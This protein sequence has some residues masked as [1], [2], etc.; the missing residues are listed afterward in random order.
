MKTP[1]PA[2]TAPLPDGLARVGRYV[3]IDRIGAGGMGIVY[4]AYDP[5]L[6]RRVAVKLLLPGRGSGQ[7][8]LA[9]EA[10]AMARVSHPNVVPVHDVG[11]IDER[12][13]IAMEFIDG[14]SLADWLRVQPRGKQ[15]IVTIFRG[16]AAGLAAAHEVGVVHRDF[17]PDNVLVD[18]KGR[19]QVTDFGLAA[20][21]LARTGDTDGSLDTDESQDPPEITRLTRTGAA[22]GTPAYMAPEQFEGGT[23]DAQSD[24]FSFCVALWEA[25]W[26][27]RPF[28]GTSAGDLAWA[29]TNGAI[30]APTA[31]TPAWLYQILVRGL[32]TDP[33]KRWPSM[34]SLLTELELGHARTRWRRIGY[35]FLG[36]F[37]VA[38][39]LEGCRRWEV[40]GRVEAC[41][42]AG[43]QIDA[44]WG[45]DRQQRMRDSFAGTGTAFAAM[46]A[47]KVVPRI[48]RQVMAWKAARAT[49]CLN[50]TVNK[51]WGA[52]TLYLADWCLEDRRT[53]L[54][55]LLTEFEHADVAVVRRALMAITS[56]SESPSC[57]NERALARQSA[58]PISGREIART[59][60]G[61]VLRATSLHLAGR[62]TIGHEVARQA[63]IRAETNLAWPPLLSAAR[64]VEGV[65]LSASGEFHD[66]EKALSEAFFE[67]A[68]AGA[69][70]VAADAAVASIVITGIK[71]SKHDLGYMWN[72]HSELAIGY[73]GDEEELREALRLNNHANMLYSTG[74]YAAAK[75]LHEKALAIRQRKLG[76]D[77]PEVARSLANLAAV[78]EDLGD[79]AGARALDEQALSIR[80]RILGPEHPEVAESLT[81]LGSVL[82]AIGDYADAQ[83]LH[84]RALAIA[85]RALG[86][87]HIDLAMILNNLAVVYD[88]L[89]ASDKA[90]AMYQRALSL[91][92]NSVGREHPSVAKTLRN[93]A[94][95]Y[96][97]NGNLSAALT[98]HERALAILERALGPE[99]PEVATSLMSIANVY[100]VMGRYTDAKSRHQRALAIREK[101]LGADNI[102][103]VASVVNLAGVHMSMGE[104]AEARR[105]Y[106]R[107]LKL[108]DG[109][110]TSDPIDVANV[111]NNLAYLALIDRRHGDAEA[112]YKRALGI[113][114]QSL[115]LEH[116]AVAA[117]LDGLAGVYLAVG[118][119]ADA[120]VLLERAVLIYEMH[121]G[122]QSNEIAAHFDLAQALV[123]TGRE[124]ERALQEAEFALN[125]YAAENRKQDKGYEEIANWL[126][127]N[128]GLLRGKE[129]TRNRA[130]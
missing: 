57:L 130:D 89:G 49:S 52:D 112:L 102:K 66:A 20:G 96:K 39:G 85:Q 118:R 76:T 92:E 99:N 37:L 105:L 5:E 71:L 77:H 125:A 53:A 50:A 7:E 120:V 58:P 4:R 67:G 75:E 94:I 29:V 23:V 80:Q 42:A 25:L 13:F 88:R 63:R 35:A 100:R 121:D 21:D 8:R 61:E 72:K 86:A 81:N 22:V 83:A 87:D 1:A 65:T 27:E 59:I 115:G 2:N 119:G 68:R 14:Q 95:V 127:K 104:T 60:R 36:A 116:P 32:S 41:H 3:I 16:A 62:F 128:K 64:Y 78:H 6:D 12:L 113:R 54:D 111:V 108:H 30:K 79:L 84:E 74:A 47:D 124:A 48:E 44:V 17:K 122:I 126:R 123:A 91:K 45:D 93:I 129:L 82:Y 55:A 31:P 117:S 114:E 56:L 28:Q 24:Q 103:I 9:R 26:G 18:R 34:T 38:G 43:A 97:E 73:A 101:A 15:E 98:H 40:A 106:E 51:S 33:A 110:S 109:A 10:R 19:P 69:W 90:L 46:A 70:D 11:S 107:A